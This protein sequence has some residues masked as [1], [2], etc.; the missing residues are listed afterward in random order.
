MALE[1]GSS[2]SRLLPLLY[3]KKKPWFLF[4]TSSPLPFHSETF[5]RKID[6]YSAE[7]RKCGNCVRCRTPQRQFVVFSGRRMFRAKF[8]S[9]GTNSWREG[10]APLIEG[11]WH[12][13]KDGYFANWRSLVVVASSYWAMQEMQAFILL[14]SLSL[15]ITAKSQ[16]FFQQKC[17][18]NKTESFQIFCTLSACGKWMLHSFFMEYLK[19]GKVKWWGRGQLLAKIKSWALDAVSKQNQT[20]GVYHVHN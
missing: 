17:D 3:Q 12:E 6:F 18:D 8:C 20:V 13:N 16:V 5:C 7:K 19:W 4:L 2:E 10:T 9:V 15:V 11:Y 1:S 14:S